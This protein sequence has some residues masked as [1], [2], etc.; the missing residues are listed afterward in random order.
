[1]GDCLNEFS[2]R[3][4]S[5]LRLVSACRFLLNLGFIGWFDD[6]FREPNAAILLTKRELL[7]VPFS[8]SIIGTLDLTR[9]E[10]SA[11]PLIVKA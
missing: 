10:F 2:I 4:A 7:D 6:N 1:M 3:P 5:A 9:R 11:L 8:L